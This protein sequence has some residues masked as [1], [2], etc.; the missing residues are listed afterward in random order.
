MAIALPVF[1]L[2]V[3]AV[4]IIFVTLFGMAYGYVWIEEKVIRL[5]SRKKKAESIV[6]TQDD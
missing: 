6:Q 3:A 5:F 4:V 1:L 2:F